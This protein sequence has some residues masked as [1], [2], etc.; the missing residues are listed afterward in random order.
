MAG[1]ETGAPWAP[2]YRCR[3][4]AVMPVAVDAVWAA[5]VDLAEWAKRWTV[6]RVE[7]IDPDTAT[8]LRPG[9]RFRIL[10]SR[11]GGPTRQWTVEVRDVAHRAHRPAVRRG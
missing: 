2:E 3:T 9:S 11:P 10:G 4:A 8:V 5:L 7:P 1:A 6:V